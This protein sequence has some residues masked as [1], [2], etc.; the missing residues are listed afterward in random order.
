MATE[1]GDKDCQCP[2][3]GGECVRNEVDIGVGI[4]RGPWRCIECGYT[5][6]DYLRA[7]FPELFEES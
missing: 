7:E 2:E 4:Q 5:E 1:L 6:R 3:C